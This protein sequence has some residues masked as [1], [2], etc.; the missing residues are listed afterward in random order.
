METLTE[1][2]TV[3]KENLQ[4]AVENMPEKIELEK[5]LD[6]MVLLAKI[7]RGQAQSRAGFTYSY[8]EAKKRLKKWSK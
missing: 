2:L 8:D 7:E 5:L 6:T 3:S 4:R 1:E